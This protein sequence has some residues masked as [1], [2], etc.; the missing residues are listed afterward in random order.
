MSGTEGSSMNI[1]EIKEQMN[2]SVNSLTIVK[3]QMKF[4]K[5]RGTH[6]VRNGQRDAV[7]GVFIKVAF[8][9]K[10]SI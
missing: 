2:K 6:R 5:K 10:G 8:E 1:Y 7:G 4:M 3:Q 9:Y